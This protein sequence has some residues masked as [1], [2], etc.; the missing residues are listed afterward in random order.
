MD[1]CSWKFNFEL[2]KKYHIP[3]LEYGV[4]KNHQEAV[5]IASEIG[6]P[7]ALKIFSQK[8]LHKSE[9]HALSL[10]L[11]SPSSIIREFKRLRKLDRRAAIIVQKYVPSSLELIVGGKFDKQFGPVILFGIGGIYTELLADFQLRVC[12]INLEQARSMIAGLKSFEILKGYRSKTKVDL[13]ALAKILV[14]V[15]QLLIENPIAEL[16]LNPILQ[17]K[18]GL[19]VADMRALYCPQIEKFKPT[20]YKPK[21][22]KKIKNLKYI[23]EPQSIAIVGASKNPSKIGHVILKNFVEGG[24]RGEIYPINLHEKEILG[25][26]CYKKISLVPKK[27]DCAIICVPAAEVYRV[28]KDAAKHKVPAA[29]VISG[30]FSEIGN[31]KEE[32]KIKKLAQKHNMALI[33]PNCMGVIN[34]EKNVDSVFLPKEKLA[35][36]K[37]G[38]IAIISQSGAIGGCLLDLANY[39]DIAISKFV[40]YGNAI[41]INETDLLH[42][43]ALD[44]STKTIALYL[45][46]IKSNAREFLSSLAYLSC[47]K[48]VVI[49]KAAKTSSGAAAALSHTSSLAG[50]SEVFSSAIKQF[51]AIEAEDIDELFDF[52]KMLNFEQQNGFEFGSNPHFCGSKIA[53]ITNGG[54]NGVLAADAIEKNGLELAKFSSATV[55]KLKKVLPPIVNITN[56]LDI[57]GD[58]TSQRYKDCLDILADEEEVDAIVCIV[59]FQTPTLD[60]SIIS[61]LSE[62]KDKIKKP[63]IVVSSGGNF[64][65]EQQRILSQNN[66]AVFSTPSTAIKALVMA[67][68]YNFLCRLNLSKNKAPL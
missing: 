19:F 30:G 18:N 51:G 45:E 50:S 4:A 6:Y 37:N 54:G 13:E 14:S 23:F 67:K 49:L 63:F 25:I 35:R 17:T 55:E 16:D 1:K 58:A 46:G 41:C 44:Q 5:R 10:N 9:H 57:L 42:Y 20:F 36:P 56:P 27:V 2:L 28:L 21:I 11:T 61:V 48:P 34:I 59:L 39:N 66:V 62:A 32:E 8:F 31:K 65:K 29:I 15:S 38:S 43:F 3:Y 22:T 24:F 47:I 52:I 53:V 33:G 40:S 60:N 12:P 26:R 64:T 68:T 7:V